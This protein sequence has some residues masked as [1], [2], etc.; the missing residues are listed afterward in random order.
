[1]IRYLLFCVVVSFLVSYFGGGGSGKP[2]GRGDL[3]ATS[4]SVL[5]DR[6][7]PGWHQATREVT[8]LAEWRHWT[9]WL[10]SASSGE[11]ERWWRQRDSNDPRAELVLERWVEVDRFRALAV[12]DEWA[13]PYGRWMPVL[14]RSW[15]DKD[16]EEAFTVLL[17]DKRR[18]GGLRDAMVAVPH[19][20]ERAYL[21][22]MADAGVTPEQRLVWVRDVWKDREVA[23]GLELLAEVDPIVGETEA[24]RLAKAYGPE[25]LDWARQPENRQYFGTVARAWASQDGSAALEACWEEADPDTRSGMLSACRFQ[26]EEFDE[27]EAW[28]RQHLET[29]NDRITL[30]GKLQDLL[31]WRDEPER[32]AELYDFWPE[33]AF[34]D[35]FRMAGVRMGNT[36]RLMDQWIAKDAQGFRDWIDTLPPRTRQVGAR[37]LF[38][39]WMQEDPIAAMARVQDE[40]PALL[41]KVFADDYWDGVPFLAGKSAEVYWEW[42]ESVPKAARPMVL[43]RRLA[44]Y[45][46]GVEESLRL[47]ERLPEGERY[48]R[49]VQKVVQR[50]AESDPERAMDFAEHLEVGVARDYAIENALRWLSRDSPERAL[51]WL[52]G[53][54]PAIW[55]QDVTGFLPEV[56]R[57]LA[58]ASPLETLELLEHVPEAD[59][60]DMQ[61]A[62][63]SGMPLSGEAFDTVLRHP[64]IS[65]DEKAKLQEDRAARTALRKALAALQ[66][67]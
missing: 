12:I 36:A 23:L 4:R 53:H 51:T 35:G 17:A 8:S 56:F 60:L 46:V 28:G 25:L 55:T 44:S 32:L 34:L 29:V 45:G 14:G 5:G 31:W 40:F 49:S 52:R 67:P 15:A 33:G 27:I 54:D 19:G 38:D 43:E 41:D 37:A 57:Y 13:Q 11:L 9:V 39:H 62:I 16:L 64:M 48:D 20:E 6:V 22:Q 42:L 66:S 21:K 26:S 2:S 47:L 59:R 24:T 65:S 50:M 30:F 61:K 18:H 7:S 58:G 63:L 1:M 3:E 10:E